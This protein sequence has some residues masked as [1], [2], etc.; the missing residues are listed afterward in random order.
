MTPEQLAEYTKKKYGVSVPS[1][2]SPESSDAEYIAKLRLMRAEADAKKQKPQGFLAETAQ[3]I[4]QTAG[5]IG[6]RFQDTLKGMS[7]IRKRQ[8][9]GETGIAGGFLQSMGQVAGGLSGAFGDVITGLAKLPLSADQEQ[10]VKGFVENVG[11]KIAELP[12]VETGVQ[13]YQQ[14]K[15]T[16][17]ELARNLESI[18]NIGMLASDVFGTGIAGK[19]AKMTGEATKKAVGTGLKKTAEIAG[20]GLKEIGEKSTG[21]AVR[22]E[23]PTKLVLQS[24]QA[25][26]P[27]LLGRVR[28]FITGNK[29]SVSLLEKPITEANTATRLGLAGTEWEMGIQAKQTA[30]NMWDSFISPA[31]KSSQVK[32]NMKDFLSDIRKEIMSM[33][34]LNRRNTLKTAFDKF[35]QDFK[36]VNNFGLEK[37]QEYKEGWAKFIPEASYKGKPIGGSLNEIRDMAAK[38]A[39]QIIYDNLGQDIKTAYFDYGNLKSIATAGIKS[40]EGLTD[41]SFSR[42]IYEMI[43]DKAVTPVATIGGQILYKTGEGLEFIGKKGAKKV[44]DIIEDTG[45]MLPKGEGEIPEKLL[46]KNWR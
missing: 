4:G 27:T 38:K 33:A 23:E 5:A 42:K 14:L 6:K 17:P 36:K 7:D 3:D 31:L 44:K 45:G 30:R 20:Q 18:F 37:L 10:K 1:V 34:D 22:M 19:G 25:S 32:V 41:K 39:R 26:N 9:T 8:Q 28:N 21:I 11:T 46:N 40:V 12:P 15:E 35:A 24:Y 2:K 43:I 13:A 29:P 16:N